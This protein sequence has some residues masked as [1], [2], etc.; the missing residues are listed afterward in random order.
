MS[1]V[2]TDY[3]PVFTECCKRQI[4]GLTDR[5]CPSCGWECRIESLSDE[6]VTK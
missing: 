4:N 1:T 3:V 6:Q 2:H 5:Y